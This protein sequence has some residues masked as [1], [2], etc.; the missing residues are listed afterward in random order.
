VSKTTAQYKKG[1]IQLY[2]DYGMGLIQ[3][4]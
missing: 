4:I 2:F 3:R 1:Q